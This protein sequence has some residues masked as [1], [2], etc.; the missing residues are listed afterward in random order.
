[1]AARVAKVG[2]PWADLH[3]K[4]HS[5]GTALKRVRV[6]LQVDSE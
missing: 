6:L 4:P 5:L 2:D 3:Q 1:M